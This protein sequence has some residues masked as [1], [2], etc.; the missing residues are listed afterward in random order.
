[1]PRQ[2]RQ[3]VRRS[4]SRPNRSWAASTPAAATAVAAATKVLLSTFTLSNPNIDETVL[5]TVGQISVSTDNTT[6]S[7]TQ[8]GA[9]GLIVVSDAAVAVGASAIPGPTS[10]AGDDGWYVYVPFSFSSVA[11]SAVGQHFDLSHRIEFDSKAK[12]IL[13]EGQTIAVMVENV[14]ASH[15]FNI[16]PIFRS[17]TMV[18]GTR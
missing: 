4:G 10:D 11:I 7:E 13:Q 15:A 18:R 1:L 6:G 5:R 17:L 12:R 3:L 14:H 2:S 16:H 9:F 8:A